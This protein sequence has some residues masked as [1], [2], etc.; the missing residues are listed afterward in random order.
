VQLDRNLPEAHAA[1]GVILPFKHQHDASIA[2][3]EKA[4]ALN[5]NFVGWRFGRAL[6]RVGD[7]KRALEVVHASM[8]LDPFCVVW[9]PLALAGAH[10]MLEQYARALPLL[11]DYVAQMPTILQVHITLAATLAR[12]GHLEDARAA[13]AEVLRLFPAF[14]IS[15][16]GRALAAFKHPR[17]EKHLFDALREVGVPE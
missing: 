7:P 4:V 8:R 12:M 2:A 6:I 5:P 9:A 10:Y 1:L 11:R 13:A 15:G 17:D 14:T 3:F 16:V